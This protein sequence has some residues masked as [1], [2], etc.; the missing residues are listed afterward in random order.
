[1]GHVNAAEPLPPL[2]QARFDAYV[3]DGA[4]MERL[5]GLVPGSAALY[6]VAREGYHAQWERPAGTC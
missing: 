5:R 2:L 4:L 3:G 1:M 6:A